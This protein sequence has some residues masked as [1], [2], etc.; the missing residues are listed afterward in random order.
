[1]EGLRKDKGKRLSG[2]LQEEEVSSPRSPSLLS[3]VKGGGSKWMSWDT[4]VAEMKR[5]K[6]EEQEV[7]FWQLKCL[8]LSWLCLVLLSGADTEGCRQEDGEEERKEAVE[9]VNKQ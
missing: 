4:V 7:N 1:M 2:C 8:V 9:K 5:R 3:G 6:A